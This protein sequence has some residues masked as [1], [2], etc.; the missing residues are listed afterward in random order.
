MYRKSVKFFNFLM[1]A[2]SK[3]IPRPASF[4]KSMMHKNHMYKLKI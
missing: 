2:Q 1:V 4:F 3:L